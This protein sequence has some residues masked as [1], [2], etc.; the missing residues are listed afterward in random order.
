MNFSVF[1]EVFIPVLIL[2]LSAGPVFITVANTAIVHGYKDGFIVSIGTLCGNIMYITIGALA[3]DGAVSSLPK[4]IANLLPLVGAGLLFNLARSFWK[5]DVAKMR[6]IK[7]KKFNF[8][9]IPKM[10]FLTLSSPVAIVGYVVIFT[11]I[12][13]NITTS[14]FSALLGGYCGAI[15]GKAIIVLVFGTIGK[16]I[17]NKVL[18]IINKFAAGLLCFYAVLLIVKVIK[19]LFF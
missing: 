7:I 16:K 11:S 1:A 5:K 14:L 2:A 17:S 10:F 6:E 8:A 19:S 4:A 13:T 9:V 15:A 3:S 12:T 18:A